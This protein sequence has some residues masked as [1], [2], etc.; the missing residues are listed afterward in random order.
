SIEQAQLA[1]E[2]AQKRFNSGV[3]TQLEIVDAM[4]ALTRSKV[5]YFNGIY[6]YFI[7]YAKL[8]QLLGIETL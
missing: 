2:I 4:V 5:N 7:S 8:Q 6:D 3:G 1:Y